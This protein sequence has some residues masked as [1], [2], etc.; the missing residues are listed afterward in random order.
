MKKLLGIVV[1]GLL[2][3]SSAFSSD[4]LANYQL[5][6]Y[7]FGES[8]IK[9]FPKSTID[10]YKSCSLPG[11]DKFCTLSMLK[12]N[13][14]GVF[15]SVQFIFDQ[16][17]VDYKIH[18][19]KG[20]IHFS[21]WNE[22]QKE[23]E[24]AINFYNSRFKNIIKQVVDERMIL[25][26]YL[27]KPNFVSDIS[28]YFNDD[29]A[30]KIGCYSVNKETFIKYGFTPKPTNIYLTMSLSSNE[31]VKYHNEKGVT[32]EYFKKIN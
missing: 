22:C 10:K 17:D 3:F 14:T 29:A 16:Y 1:L 19:L 20:D 28:F 11:G 25:Q 24:S 12:D 31:F 26:T 30:G 4:E 5:G 13:S 18:S 15:D 6:K 32:K 9:Y 8:L 2:L 23:Q 7:K 21:K 27:E